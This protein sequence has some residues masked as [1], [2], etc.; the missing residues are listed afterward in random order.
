MLF[1]R[2]IIVHVCEK[3]ETKS[4]VLLLFI[5]ESYILMILGVGGGALTD[6]TITSHGDRLVS[7]TIVAPLLK[8]IH[9]KLT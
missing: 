1:T 8:D 9:I 6:L 7:L 5:L 2:L 3:K 4:P